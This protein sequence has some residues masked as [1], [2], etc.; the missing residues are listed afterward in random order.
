[1]TETNAERLQR[2]ADTLRRQAAGEPTERSECVAKMLEHCK[3]IADFWSE[4]YAAPFVPMLEAALKLTRLILEA[5]EPTAQPPN[6][7]VMIP[8]NFGLMHNLLRL[9]AAVHLRRAEFSRAVLPMLNLFATV[10]WKPERAAIM[11]PV[12]HHSAGWPDPIHL[13]EIV[14]KDADQRHLV[15]TLPTEPPASRVGYREHRTE[16]RPRHT[17][18]TPADSAPIDTPVPDTRPSIGMDRCPHV[19]VFEPERNQPDQQCALYAG[20]LDRHETQPLAPIREDKADGVHMFLWTTGAN[21]TVT[22]ISEQKI[23]DDPDE[24]LGELDV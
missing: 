9:P 4:P 19:L 21:G 3:M 11:E 12:Y 24:T 5:G 17:P 13:H 2:A 15:S 23:D 22:E 7:E 10:D 1:V 16:Q 20:H 14:W 8:I 6:G 18:P